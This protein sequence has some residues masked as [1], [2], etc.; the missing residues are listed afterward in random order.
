[1][2]IIAEMC[3]NHNGDMDLLETMVVEAAKNGADI[4]KIQTI[5]AK[6]LIY[7]KEFEDFR[8]YEKEYERLKSLELSIDDEKKFV[9]ICRQNKVE[10]M[11]TVFE[12][13]GFKRFN[14]V[15][16]KLM[17]ISGYGAQKVLPTIKHFNF[18]HLYISTSSMT[19][20]EIEWLTKQL[21]LNLPYRNY[22]LLN[23]TCVYPTPLEKLNLQN[24]EFYRKHFGIKN[25][26]LSDHTNPYEDNL[27][28]SKLAIYQG[29]DVLERHF[30][31]LGKDETRDGKV[32]ITPDM[33]SEL[34]R[35]SLL[36]PQDQYNEINEFDE[37][38]KF[39][40]HYYRNRF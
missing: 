37:T 27:L 11:T 38:Q 1:M 21:K 33:L 14:D 7:W 20:R 22:T 23:C 39:N 5:E 31:I 13:R 12:H 9:A 28:S 40:H 15:G 8:P 10:P 26:G 16:Y 4:C 25:V 17:K 34:K 35:F 24:I 3:Q 18:E 6:H 29:I 32:S 2:K 30:T 19:Y 36:A